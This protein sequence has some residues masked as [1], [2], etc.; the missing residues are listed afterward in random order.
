MAGR[1]ASMR[2]GSDPA[3]PQAIEVT[4]TGRALRGGWPN[5]NLRAVSYFAEPAEVPIDFSKDVDG[6]GSLWLLT[7]A[8]RGRPEEH[9]KRMPRRPVAD[10]PDL[11]L[12]SGL[13]GLG[14]LHGDLKIDLLSPAVG[15]PLEGERFFDGSGSRGVVQGDGKG[16]PFGF[17]KNRPHGASFPWSGQIGPQA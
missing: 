14:D 10:L 3:N 11:D 12:L 2:P 13:L 1:Q 9:T 7:A 17:K 15:Y 5:N 6:A 4:R 16:N 8:G